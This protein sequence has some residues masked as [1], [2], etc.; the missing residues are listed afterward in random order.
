M[1]PQVSSRVHANQF[2]Q[3]MA[4]DQRAKNR[5][6]ELGDTVFIKNFADE[7]TWLPGVVTALHGLLTF[8]VKLGD[9]Q[10]VW[11]H[12][13]HVQSQASHP[14][15]TETEDDCTTPWTD[16][17]FAR[18]SSVAHVLALQTSL[19]GMSSYVIPFV[20][21]LEFSFLVV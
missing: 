11:R 2:Q 21:K 5:S 9:G 3:K 13:D 15:P 17:C 20:Y 4:H 12:I 8:D 16:Y 7:P 19:S 6:F 18:P 10:V 1:H 14:P